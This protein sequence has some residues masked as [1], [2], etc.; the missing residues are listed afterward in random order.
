M[1]K[2]TVQHTELLKTT[3]TIILTSIGM[4]LRWLLG[5]FG[6]EKQVF[7]IGQVLP[8]SMGLIEANGALRS[9][10]TRGVMVGKFPV[11]YESF[12]DDIASGNRKKI[13]THI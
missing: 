12:D 7:L 5:T 10:H 8:C 3:Y 9:D 1:Q 13:Y 6:E 2:N 4:V 11:F